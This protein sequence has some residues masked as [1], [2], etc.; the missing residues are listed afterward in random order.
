[1][2]MVKIQRRVEEYC[3]VCNR[4]RIFVTHTDDESKIIC[5]KCQHTQKTG[6]KRPRN[7]KLNLVGSIYEKI[8]NKMKGESL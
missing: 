5:T 1:M 3:Q 8:L 2:K 7:E 6:Y 4:V